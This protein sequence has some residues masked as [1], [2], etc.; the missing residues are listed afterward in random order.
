M[1]GGRLCH[2][3][4]ELEWSAAFLDSAKDFCS[5]TVINGMKH[6]IE[7]NKILFERL[8]WFVIQS[9]AV[10]AALYLVGQTWEDFTTNPTVT[11]LVSQNYPVNKVP[12]PAV[13]LCNTNRLSR[14]AVMEYALELYEKS[15]NSSRANKSVEYYF[16]MLRYMGRLID[17][18]IEGS[19]EFLEFQ[20][21]LDLI[22]T[23]ENGTSTLNIEDIM[24]RLTPKCSDL[25][26][27]CRYHFRERNCSAIFELRKTI[28][29]QCCIFNY[30]RRNSDFK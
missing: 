26:L 7:V 23:N 18:D 30:V 16:D 14:Q 8:F 9:V 24:Q 12:F 28:F 5:R 13:A 27:L 20:H 3:L 2:R 21:I 15:K 1:A 29:G 19:R 10:S 4:A 17:F 22:E 11:T 25:L 6:V